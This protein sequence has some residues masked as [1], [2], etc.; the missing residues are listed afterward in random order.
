MTNDDIIH[1]FRERVAIM[2]AEKIGAE[3][4]MQEA[5]KEMSDRITAS[6]NHKRKVLLDEFDKLQREIED[7]TN[8]AGSP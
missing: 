4:A 3:F 5:F 1:H 8:Q 7:E 2:R 6:V